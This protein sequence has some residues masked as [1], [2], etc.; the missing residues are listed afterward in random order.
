MKGIKV[1]HLVAIAALCWVILICFQVR[2]IRSSHALIEEQFDQKVSLALCAAV[3][4]LDSATAVSCSAPAGGIAGQL[5]TL[6]LL[7][8]EIPEHM[9]I[10]D[11]AL[12]KAVSEA[13]AFYD[14]H[15]PFYI[16][17]E[18]TTGPGCDPMS[19]YCCVLN[20]FQVE[21]SALMRIEFPGKDAY[22][23]GKMW[24]ML[25]SSLF[26]LLF[27]LAVFVLALR[28][29]IRQQRIS[30]WNIDFFNNMAH[31]FKTPVTNIRLAAQRLVKRHPELQQ[32][33]YLNIV[34]KEDAKLGAQIDSI[35]Q[36]A[37]FENHRAY[38]NKERLDLVALLRDLLEEMQLQIRT[39]KGHVALSSPASAVWVTADRFHLSHVFRNLIENALKYVERRPEIRIQ[40][41]SEGM[42]VR[43]LVTDNGVGIGKHH[44]DLIFRKFHRAHNG[45]RHDYKG[46]G[47]GLSYARMI[48][49]D[50]GGALRLIETSP[51]G[52]V[53][54]VI[55]PAAEHSTD[56]SADE[57][58]SSATSVKPQVV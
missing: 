54:E 22:L 25:A 36:L 33:P 45:T 6:G 55:L 40:M 51:D 19:P 49:H 28:S 16:V 52:S 48:V 58:A 38:L 42:I 47:L 43:C 20:P 15:L 7:E 57:V 46:F 21:D 17:V 8:P 56:H 11:S 24:F 34:R 12:N 5:A 9:E 1:P 37:Q 26:I 18:N 39:V 14:I 53:F 32:D 44:R 41:K 2:W 4:S 31:E 50:H 3:G 29:L 30:Q 23:F 35:L 10:N 13:L 27:I